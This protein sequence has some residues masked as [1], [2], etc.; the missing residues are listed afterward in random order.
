MANARNASEALCFDWE[1]I[2]IGVAVGTITNHPFLRSG[3]LA[4]RG[5]TGY[6]KHGLNQAIGRNGGKGIHPK[7][8]LDALR[9]P[10]RIRQ[11]PD[12]RTRIDG[13]NGTTVVQNRY[14]RV[15]TTFGNNPRG[16]RIRE[17]G[18]QRASGGGRAQRRANELGFSYNPEAIR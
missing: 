9:D 2:L 10:K 11:F 13:K 15:V 7:A 8:I 4:A 5:F 14:G 3:K 12:G 16:P 6:T 18:T 17:E 1:Q